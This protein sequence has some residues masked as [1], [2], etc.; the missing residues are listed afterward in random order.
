MT[1]ILLLSLSL[2]IFPL[3]QTPAPAT[4]GLDTAAIDQA[5]GRTG[6]MQDGGVY[7]V[8]AP[9]S[10]L[11]VTVNGIAIRP[12]LALGS[13]MAFK[14]AANNTVAHGD[15]V[16]LGTEVNPVI[17][18]LQQGGMEITAVHNHVIGE[19]PM[20]MY[21]HFWGQGAEAQLART[22]AAVLGKTATPA[23]ST[24][25]ADTAPFKGGD[26]LQTA[27]GR[28]GTVRNG[29]LAVSVARPEKITM[30][31]VELPPSMGMATALNFQATDDG[32][33]A[34]TGDF[35]MIGDEVN[36]VA[37]ALRDH[38][39]EISALHSHMIHGSPELY[40]MHFWTVGTPEKV[41]GGLK[42]AL[43]QMKTQ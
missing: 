38:D 33:I 21:V 31:G 35:V 19:S 3:Q 26:E 37:K 16:L 4:G 39:I 8:T 23:A 25:A 2:F 12:G 10:D 6:Q 24:A 9:R 36:R 28:K 41:G 40:F 13:W 34:G 1:R 7:K 32:R 5:L 29:V 15:L 20:V 17:S 43:G 11:K 14:R 22:L 42:A 30:M 27:L 18:A